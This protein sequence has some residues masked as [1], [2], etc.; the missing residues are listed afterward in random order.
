MTRLPLVAA[1]MAG[2]PST[3][4]LVV[5]AAEAGALGLLAAGYTTPEALAAE[6]RAVRQRTDRFGVNLFVPTPVPV[7]RGAYAAYADRLHPL[8]ARH[9][10]T[11]LPAEPREDDDAWDAKVD[12]LL[13]DPV[14][15]VSF[16]FGLPAASVVR[17]FRD[18]GTSTVQ[19]VV[20]PSEAELAARAGVDV[21]VVQSHVAGGHSGTFDPDDLPPEVPLTALLREVRTVTDLPLWAA[22]G[23]ATPEDVA[24]VL[25]AGAEAAVVGTALLRTPEA[26][27]SATYRRALVDPARTATGFTRAFSGR[28]ARALRNGFVEAYDAV[29]PSGY[30]AVHHLTSPIRKAAAAAG[31][32]EAI[33]IWAGTGFRS[34]TDEPAGVVLRRLA[35]ASA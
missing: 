21:L 3:P 27:T 30:P 4:A 33:N 24:A 22:G 20:R 16:T 10:V 13:A 34:A 5:A 2:G 11:T 28:P 1:P 23:L 29:A 26:G 9:G 14:P 19:T 32:A 15:V 35:G 12:L 6:I 18:V 7:D 25:A 17:A 31:D 8:A